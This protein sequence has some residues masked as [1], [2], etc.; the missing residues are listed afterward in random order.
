MIYIHELVFTSDLL[1]VLYLGS[2]TKDTKIKTSNCR[3]FTL[4]IFH[5]KF[6]SNKYLNI[7]F[8]GA[9]P[10]ITTSVIL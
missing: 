4:F 6:Y 8:E 5:A 1:D 9:F 3:I 2:C 10:L 7:F